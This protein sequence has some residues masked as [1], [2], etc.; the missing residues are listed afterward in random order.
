MIQTTRHLRHRTPALLL[1]AATVVLAATQVAYAFSSK[2][3]DAQVAAER[4][5]QLRKEP[6][7]KTEQWLSTLNREGTLGIETE[8]DE[9][10]AWL[11][12]QAQAFAEFAGKGA[13]ALSA[14]IPASCASADPFCPLK[15]DSRVL[16]QIIKQHF[17]QRMARG[18]GAGLQRVKSLLTQAKLEDLKSVSV[19]ELGKAIRKFQ[20]FEP[21]EGAAR[22]VIESKE[23]SMPMLAVYLGEKAEEFLPDDEIR[24]KAIQLYENASRCGDS[25]EKSRASYRYSLLQI[26][27]DHCDAALPRLSELS[28]P[29]QNKDYRSRALYWQAYCGLKAGTA[30]AK[31]VAEQARQSLLADFPFSLH[32]LMLEREEPARLKAF[33]AIP[34]TV[35]RFRSQTVPSL[36]DTVTAAESLL[37]ADEPGWARRVLSTISLKADGAEPEFQIYLA[38]LFNQVGDPINKFRTLTVAFRDHPQSI[39]RV[40]LELYYPR[41]RELKSDV[42]RASGVDQFV[43]MALIRQE[44]AFNE[45]ARSPAGA[46][47]LMQVMPRTARLIEHTRRRPNLWDPNNN[48]R[49]GSKY[50]SSLLK[51][52]DGDTELALAAYNAGPLRVEQWV[53]RYNV[54]RRMLF[55]DLIPF[56]ETREYVASIARNYYWY[57]ALYPEESATVTEP[58]SATDPSG[59]HGIGSIFKIFGT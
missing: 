56:R 27:A 31:A 54:S 23:C 35:V 42:L 15:S 53:K 12:E 40:S 7:L 44:S 3:K 19:A 37:S 4:P 58:S 47:G 49:I 36:N 32:S 18:R 16:G 2:K 55:L 24:K 45:R 26:W 8:T 13:K 21:L 20:T 22:A 30:E 39:S 9:R 28:A 48:V 17:H 1:G 46:V 38:W 6:N 25:D 5:E 41:D 14:E 43:V 51:R 34:D 10:K 52:Y 33:L 11:K 59:N 50:F 57:S 29:G